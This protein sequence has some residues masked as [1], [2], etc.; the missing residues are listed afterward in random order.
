MDVISDDP[1]Y[2]FRQRVMERYTWRTVISELIEPLIDELT[3][4]LNA[5]G[6]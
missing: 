2:G 1:I 5:K 3:G 6:R 4:N